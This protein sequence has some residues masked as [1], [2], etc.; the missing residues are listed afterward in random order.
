MPAFAEV[1]A[2]VGAAAADAEVLAEI[3]V[4]GLLAIAFRP[5]LHCA[6]L[7]LV[8]VE[9]GLVDSA[10]C[11]ATPAAAQSSVEAVDEPSA[12]RADPP[13]AVVQQSVV[14]QACQAEY[15]LGNFGATPLLICVATWAAP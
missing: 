2:T 8:A 3:S 12:A 13:L 1:Y 6:G 7:I 11:S 14:F 9:S 4:L 5:T 15:S 10:I